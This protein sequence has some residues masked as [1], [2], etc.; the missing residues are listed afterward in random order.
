MGDRAEDS[1]QRNDSIA[2]RLRS[3]AGRD[4]VFA[5]FMEKSGVVQ[6]RNRHIARPHRPTNA[7]PPEHAKGGGAVEEEE[8]TTLLGAASD[9]ATCGGDSTARGFF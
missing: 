7:L 6:Q 8:E 1:C 4:F 9:G 5:Q 3:S 2:R